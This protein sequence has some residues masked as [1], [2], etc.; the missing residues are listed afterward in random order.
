MVMG[1]LFSIQKRFIG[2]NVV[3]SPMYKGR[4]TCFEGCEVVTRL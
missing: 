3:T 4:A 1:I 2:C